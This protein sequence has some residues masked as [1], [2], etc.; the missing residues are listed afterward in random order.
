MLTFDHGN[1]ENS[2]SQ[3]LVSLTPSTKNKIGGVTFA[4][5]PQVAIRENDSMHIFSA[6][7]EVSVYLT[8]SKLAHI[9]SVLQNKSSTAFCKN[10][11]NSMIMFVDKVNIPYEGYSVHIKSMS[12]D[13]PPVH[14]RIILNK[15]EGF[16]LECALSS[17]MGRIAFG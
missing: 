12:N 9:L 7:E 11:P 3:L 14:G 10:L 6:D 15:T 16:A 5:R 17:S 8:V 13:Y 4:I 2:G 1:M